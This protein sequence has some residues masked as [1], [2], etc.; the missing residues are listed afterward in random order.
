MN[1]Q[2]FL[3]S[4]TRQQDYRY[5][6]PLPAM[7]EGSRRFVGA[8]LGEME[9]GRVDGVLRFFYQGDDA[10]LLRLTESGTQDLYGRPIASLEGVY[11]PEPE[12]LRFWTGL[13][14]LLPRLYAAP[15]LYQSCVQGENILPPASEQLVER[16]IAGGWESPLEEDLERQLSQVATPTPFSFGSEGLAL[17]AAPAERV[18]WQQRE[19]RC[20]DLELIVDRRE[21][22]VRL[23]AVSCGKPTVRLLRSTRIHGTKEG[24]PLVELFAAADAM[25]EQLQKK[26]WTYRQGGDAR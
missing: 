10:V 15:P 11:I 2:T 14:A 25:M 7:S 13:S 16:W 12:V 22:A 17:D 6:L 23:E 9:R 24:W 20:Y 4:R 18:S 21:K 5:L 26:G 3:F 1:V 19:L 8:Q